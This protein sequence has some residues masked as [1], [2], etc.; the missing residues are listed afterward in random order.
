M[1]EVIVDKPKQRIIGHIVW[2]TY[3]RKSMLREPPPQLAVTSESAIA[4]E[5]LKWGWK[6]LTFQLLIA[7]AEVKAPMVCKKIGRRE[8]RR[9]LK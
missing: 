8:R 4:V 2:R 7:G 3:N 6:L 9:W 5:R 1:Y